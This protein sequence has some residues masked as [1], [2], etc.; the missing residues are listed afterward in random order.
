M[1]FSSLIRAAV[2]VLGISTV[3]A[4]PKPAGTDISVWS[5]NPNLTPRDV[6]RL[7]GRSLSEVSHQK[8][9]TVFSNSTSFEQ[10]WDDAVLL[11]LE[12]TTS[13]QRSNSEQVERTYSIEVSCTTCY[14]KGEVLAELKILEPFNISETFNNYTDQIGT[15]IENTTDVT[16][17][18][19]KNYTRG[20][21]RNL[22]DGFDLDDFDLPPLDVDFDIGIPTIPEVSLRFQ[23][24][25][26]ELYVELET[27]FSAGITYTLNLFASK[28]QFGVQISEDLFF[29]AVVVVDLILSADSE[30]SISS[31]FHIKIDDASELEL[32]LFS[33]EVGKAT[34][35]GEFEFLPVTIESAGVVLKAVLRIKLR[36]GFE[37]STPPIEILGID[38]S[39]ILDL[40]ASAGVEV[41]VWTHLAELTTNVTVVPA[42]D[43][44]D[45]CQLRVEE[46]YQIGVG[47]AAG[48]TV[49]LAD[50]TWGPAP[51]FTIPLFSTA[52]TQCAIQAIPSSTTDT[53]SGTI[54]SAAT[55]AQRQAEET[56]T[57]TTIS[58]VVTYR[59]VE[60][61]SFEMVDCPVSL[62]RTTKTTTELTLVTA[63]PS[64]VVATFPVTMQTTG[65]E[66]SSFGTNVRRL[67]ETASSTTA[68]PSATAES[69]LGFLDGDINGVDKRIIFGVSIGGGILVL[70]I[71]IIG[72]IIYY[73]KKTYLAV[74]P[75]PQGQ[76]MSYHTEPYKPGMRYDSDQ[77]VNRTGGTPPRRGS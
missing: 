17:N 30:I 2:C 45:G 5:E 50:H 33:D 14:L 53:S 40:R 13:E 67:Y 4:L 20:V 55:I 70:A 22:A 77:S 36:V 60:C 9:D 8:R 54:T 24:D 43:E 26:L 31:G 19:I 65:V 23:F 58:T 71:V 35:D 27:V 48:A 61:M 1:L 15:I 52:I 68:G 32:G 42:G 29:G 73:R 76:A 25:D 74:P 46:G 51:T 12:Y 66:P 18:Y 10:R 6:M 44:V 75:P 64:G 28:T 47:A 59:G 11:S 39:D 7:L 34:L 49:A 37:I 38:V 41:S 56:L 3:Q 16:L 62:Q 21:F 57:M 63:V 72:F 69:K